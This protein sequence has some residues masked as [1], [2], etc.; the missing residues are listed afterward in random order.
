MAVIKRIQLTVGVLFRLIEEHQVVLMPIR[1][2]RTEQTHAPVDVIKDKAPEVTHKRLRPRPD[3]DEVIV[4]AQ[5]RQLVFNKPFI[6]RSAIA[7]A[8]CPLPDIG[9]HDGQ[10]L[11]I[12]VVHIEDWRQADLPVRRL[13]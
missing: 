4:A 8:S 6:Q 10:F 9:I 3:R 5:I 12:E 2:G 13:K 1:L 7:E 11:R